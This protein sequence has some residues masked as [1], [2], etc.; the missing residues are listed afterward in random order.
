MS[1]NK[2]S[3]KQRKH[4]MA[5]NTSSQLSPFPRAVV[6]PKSPQTLAVNPR[7]HLVVDIDD[8]TVAGTFAISATLIRS[9]IANQT[10]VSAGSLYFTLEYIH[11]WGANSPTTNLG[12]SLTDLV[13]GTKSRGDNTVVE[14]GRAGISW[15][16]NVQATYPPS[17]TTAIARVDVEPA[18][19][20]QDFTLRVG[21]MYWG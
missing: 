6:P 2:S 18:L 5:S 15:P 14:R 10:V 20:E 4:V 12:I 7:R 17:D 16:K 13:Y 3:S 11:V 21:V 1:A 9:A 8:I 19:T